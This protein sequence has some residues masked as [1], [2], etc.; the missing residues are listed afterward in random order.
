MSCSALFRLIPGA[1]V[2]NAPKYDRR[3]GQFYRNIGAMPKGGQAKFF[4]GRD[5]REAA[6]RNARLDQLW[7]V[8][9]AGEPAIRGD[10]DGRHAWDEH[11][12]YVIAR[13]IATGQPAAVLALPRSVPPEWQAR[14]LDDLRTRYGSIIALVSD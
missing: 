13:A 8:I 2:T 14:W 3:R 5:G 11:T 10:S 6:V 4:L 12:T 9:K 7:N 1:P